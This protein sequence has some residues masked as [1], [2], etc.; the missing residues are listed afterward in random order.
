MNK[1]LKYTLIGLTVVG[2]G[3]FL[4]YFLNMKN[5]K[6]KNNLKTFDEKNME[7][8]SIRL[9]F[10]TDISTTISNYINSQNIPFKFISINQLMDENS[11]QVLDYNIGIL[12]IDFIKVKNA[13]YKLN[14]EL[15]LKKITKE[16]AQTKTIEKSICVVNRDKI[17][18]FEEFYESIGCSDYTVLFGYDLLGIKNIKNIEN[19]VS[20]DE[21]IDIYDVVT[22]KNFNLS[23]EKRMYLT[24]ILKKIHA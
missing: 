18:S 16:Q 12:P 19:K 7:F 4:L 3:V 17:N 10:V 24:N 11:K 14:K 13:I 9:P 8:Y 1:G 23:D 2:T 21:L 20:L 15:T 5:N 6:S 22:S